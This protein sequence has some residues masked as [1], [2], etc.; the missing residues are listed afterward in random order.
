M[1]RPPV[2][3]NNESRPTPTKDHH[4]LLVQGGTAAVSPNQA[5]LLTLVQQQCPRHFA[6]LRLCGHAVVQG[7]QDGFPYICTKLVSYIY[8]YVPCS[9]TSVAA[10]AVS[11]C[12][13]CSFSGLCY[14]CIISQ[15][16]TLI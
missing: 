7:K 2:K 14:V 11:A 16:S 10:A 4:D 3:I 12:G 8:I 5:G 13:F 1:Q 6:T 15:S 9:S